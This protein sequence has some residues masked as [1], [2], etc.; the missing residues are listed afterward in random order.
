M[1]Y[2]TDLG[3]TL[4]LKLTALPEAE[5]NELITFVKTEVLTSYRNGQRDAD[6]KTRPTGKTEERVSKRDPKVHTAPK[7][8]R[9][10]QH[11]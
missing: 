8:R 5:R 7:E 10:Y 2:L 1:S 6:K 3:N 4:A 11:R 9:N